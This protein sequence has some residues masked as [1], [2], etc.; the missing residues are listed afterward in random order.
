[1]T[2]GNILEEKISEY[3]SQGEY[4]RA[5]SLDA[6][7]TVAVGNLSRDIRSLVCQEAKEHNFKT[8]R[9]FSPGYGD[10]DISQ[11]KNIF[12]I[13]P[14]CKIGAK[15]TNSFMMVPKKSSSWVIGIGKNITMP[16][17]DDNSCK[18]CKAMKCQFKKIF[19]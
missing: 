9:Y 16:S 17:K 11:Q 15:L 2:I 8:T 3:F 4:P 12:E 18:I 14:A 19:N 10:W 5:V 13:I 7:G 6:V 1:M